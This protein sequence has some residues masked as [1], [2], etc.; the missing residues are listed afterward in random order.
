ME[1]K[2][3]LKNINEK[4]TNINKTLD[5]AAYDISRFTEELKEAVANATGNTQKEVA[6]KVAEINSKIVSVAVDAN[7]WVSQKLDDLRGKLEEEKNKIINNL[8]E[9]MADKA[10]DKAKLASGGV[11]TKV[12][13]VKLKAQKA[14]DKAEE[15]KLAMNI[16]KG[17]TTAITN[18]NTVAKNGLA[19]IDSINVTG[20]AKEM[21]EQE[22]AA[23]IS[24]GNS[25]AQ[26]L[27]GSIG[28]V[29]G[30]LDNE[31]SNIKNMVQEKKAAIANT[32][33]K[34]GTN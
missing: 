12:E 25:L 2:Q 29:T 5:K 7:Q 6:R 4:I 21:V 17:S 33:N 9:K 15:A 20:I 11:L 1:T 18:V 13:W 10:Y 23:L 14:K 16:I 26:T 8:K 22:L 28:S 30:N 24:M 27:S 19:V 32:K 34:I 31:Y 3:L